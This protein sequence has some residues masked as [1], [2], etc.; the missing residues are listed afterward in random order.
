MAAPKVDYSVYLVTDSTPAI[1]GDADLASV[2]EQSLQGGVT[3]VQYRDKHSPRDHVVATARKLH[4]I[5]Q[6]YNVPFLI[7]DHV[8]VAAEIGCEGVHIGQDD[9]AFEE[10]KRLLGEGK[11]I[12]ITASSKEEALK[13]ASQGATYLGIGTV[14][15]T[16]TKK[17]TKSIIGPVGVSSILAALAA[18]GHGALPTV[19][20]GGVNASNARD[21]MRQT[22]SPRKTL[23][24]VAVVSAIVAARDP[25]AAAREIQ[26][27]VIGAK[28]PEVILSIARKGPLSH[29]MTNLVVQNFAANVALAIGASPIMANYAEEAADLAKL[30]GALVVNMGTVTPDGLKNYVQ[31]LQAY[32]A[33]KRPVVFDPVGAGATAVRRSAVKTLLASG[34]FTLIKG[35]EGELQTLHGVSVTQH[36]VDSTSTL[37]LAQKARLARDL[38]RTHAAVVLLTGK[39]DIV[40]D[41]TRTLRVDNGHELLGMITGTGCTLGTTVSAAL[42]AHGHVDPLVAAVAGTAMFGVAAEMAAARSE[43]RGPGTFV[44][45]FLDELYLIRK[46]SA[47]GD[48]RWLTMVKV[49]AVEV[50]EA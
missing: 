35:N 19:C 32:N 20:I 17:D 1:L 16:S 37:S 6:K 43:V 42:A 3:I 33:A 47:D 45:A 34:H 48:M 9:M 26:G 50:Q 44:P 30:G 46:A 2:V 8:D 5:T 29:N 49:Q 39:T 25:A 31:A 36:G 28:I 11:I 15:A 38:A 10:A 13:A 40:S 22:V 21:V 27:A 18:E 12:G 4:Q 41:G 14:Y 24:G 23:D 7:N